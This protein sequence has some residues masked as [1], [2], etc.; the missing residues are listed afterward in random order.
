MKFVLQDY[1]SLSL[2]SYILIQRLF[3]KFDDEVFRVEHVELFE[4]FS[5]V[6]SPVITVTFPGMGTFYMKGWF[7][8][9]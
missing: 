5:V 9:E 1:Q 4:N 8:H 7:E 3:S 2:E 6:D